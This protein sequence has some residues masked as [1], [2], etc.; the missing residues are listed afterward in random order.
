[1]EAELPALQLTQ[2][3]R[4]E[5][6]ARGRMGHPPQPGQGADAGGTTLPPDIFQQVMPQLVTQVVT[7]M[8]PQLMAGLAQH[9][10]GKGQLQ[11]MPANWAVIEAPGRELLRQK[12]RAL[13][14]MV[15]RGVHRRGEHRRT[16]SKPILASKH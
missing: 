12:Q 7:T 1:M 11:L 3:D 15:D 10:G 8:V 4:D 14:E 5:A 9:A 6:A 13:A 2:E 16:V